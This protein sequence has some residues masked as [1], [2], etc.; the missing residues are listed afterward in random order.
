MPIAAAPRYAQPGRSTEATTGLSGIDPKIAALAPSRT[1][2]GAEQDDH[3]GEVLAR[4]VGDDA[5][6]D[7][8]DD[9]HGDD[10]GRGIRAA[11]R[12]GGDERRDPAQEAGDEQRL[13]EEPRDLGE[14][15][16]EPGRRVGADE[17]A[18]DEQEE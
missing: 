18:S 4:Q 14:L 11:G 6:D 13:G 10:R 16:G 12:P 2:R 9:E 8:R 1:S 15:V 5:D 7:R 3:P 17:D